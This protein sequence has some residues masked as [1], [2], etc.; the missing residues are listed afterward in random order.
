MK[1][2]KSFL[3]RFSHWRPTTGMHR[4]GQQVKP[5]RDPAL[6]YLP[7]LPL[8]SIWLGAFREKLRHADE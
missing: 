3:C 6:S 7:G 5:C 4:P 2:K 1:K 8:E